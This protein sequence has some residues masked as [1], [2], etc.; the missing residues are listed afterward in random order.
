M[1]TLSHHTQDC[2]QCSCDPGGSRSSL[3]DKVYGLCPCRPHMTTPSCDTPQP[4]YYVPYPHWGGLVP[5]TSQ[6]CVLVWDNLDNIL[7]Q[8]AECKGPTTV[9]FQAVDWLM[10]P[11]MTW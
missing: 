7:D 4:G 2:L 1:S 5:V 10:Q 11:D 9:N 6:D 3:C 8:F